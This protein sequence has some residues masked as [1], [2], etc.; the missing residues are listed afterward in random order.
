MTNFVHN[1]ADAIR[2]ACRSP[3]VYTFAGRSGD[4]ASFWH[5]VFMIFVKS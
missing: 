2:G 5:Q 4:G 3:R 1:L